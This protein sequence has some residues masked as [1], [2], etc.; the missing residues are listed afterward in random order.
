MPENILS[1]QISALTLIHQSRQQSNVAE[2]QSSL[3]N[4]S[5]YSEDDVRNALNYL[6][7]R[8]F[9]AATQGGYPF[10]V[11]MILDITPAGIDFLNQ[12]I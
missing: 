6:A 7:E 4:N 12:H 9:I 5:G 8:N 2:I 1:C 10:H 11:T 3:V